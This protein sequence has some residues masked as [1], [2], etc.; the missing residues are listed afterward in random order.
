MSL[1]IGKAVFQEF[2]SAVCVTNLVLLTV[3]IRPQ[4]LK[5]GIG[6][7]DEI[8]NALSSMLSVGPSV[9]F[10]RGLILPFLVFALFLSK[11][12][13]GKISGRIGDR[14]RSW[15]PAAGVGVIAGF[16]FVWSNDYGISCWVCL[17]IMTFWT[18]YSRSRKPG[19]AMAAL[20]LELICSVLGI[21]VA[22]EVF[23]AGHLPE[24]LHE[25]LGTGNYQ[26]WYYLC[27]KSFYLFDIDTSYPTL[28]QAL[29]ACYYLIMLFRNRADEESLRRYGILGFA[30]MTCFCEVNEY[31]LLSGGNNREVAYTVLFLTAAFEILRLFWNNLRIRRAAQIASLML[32]T[33]WIL[34]AVKEELLSYLVP[35]QTENYVEALGGNMTELYDDLMMARNFLDGEEFWSTYASAQEVVEGRFQ[36]SGTDY[37]IHALGDQAREEYLSAFQNGTFRYAATLRK[38]YDDWEYWIERANWYFYRE[39][40]QNWHPVFQNSYEVYW[41]RNTADDRYTLTDNYDVKI[42]KVD[43]STIKLI[44]QTD[45]SVN[46]IADVYVEYAVKEIPESRLGKLMFQKMLLVQNTGETY[47]K[48]TF[49]EENYLREESGEYIPMPI[50]D[51]YGE[52][53]LTSQPRQRT[54]LDL[55]TADCSAIYTAI[56]EELLK[57]GS[58]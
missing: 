21:L 51:G 19:R 17:A 13:W 5:Y 9:R 56:S 53:T 46:G 15:I 36:P 27:D 23:T 24:W 55:Y 1:M 31:K 32:G 39:L 2:R 54:T 57:D 12:A 43:D 28:L 50:T 38:S 16:A 52:L 10:V 33:V 4:F 18:V 14:Y 26:A 20:G 7:P 42:E 3:L 11:K 34:S 6:M 44:V 47:A 48:D 40:Y 37:I 22:A 45:P 35:S 41:E 30:N 58:Q 49:Y 29:F 25:I 8:T